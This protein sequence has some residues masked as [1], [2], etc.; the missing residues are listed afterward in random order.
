M[1][2]ALLAWWDGERL[3]LPWRR[4]RT[5]YSVW[6]SEVMLQQTVI[7]AV[8]PH[9]ERWMRVYPDAAALAAASEREVTRLW[10]GLGYYSRARHL[11]AASRLVQE[12]WG[13]AVPAAYDELRSL[14]GVGDY[15]ARAILSIAH[16][17]RFAVVDANVRR[18]VQ[19]LLA[20]PDAPADAEAQ[21]ALEARMPDGRAG[22][23]NEALMELGQRVCI[24]GEPRCGSCPLAR[25]C[26]ARS[27]GLE[28]QIP[29]RGHAEATTRQTVALV[30]LRRGAVRLCSHERGLFHGLWTFPR[31]PEPQVQALTGAAGRRMRLVG[32]L[33]PRTHTYTRYRERLLPRVYAVTAAA[34]AV[35]AALES[36]GGEWVPLSAVGGRPMPSAHRRIAEELLAR[37]D[38]LGQGREATTRA[39]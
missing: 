4:D 32:E 18:V 9:Y 12:R 11:L 35:T 8:V 19:R 22:D 7:K 39:R 33:R 13:G 24:K 2:R 5:P 28:R 29:A 34:A 16:G 3:D 37:I 31:L 15:T 6:V 25:G 20:L 23:F 1:G 21:Q 30:L 17:C 36:C 26:L 14:P 27:L 10:E 38:E